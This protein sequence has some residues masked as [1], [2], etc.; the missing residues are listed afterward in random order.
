MSFIG[1]VH[2]HFQNTESSD[3]FV[4]CRDCGTSLEL[5]DEVCPSCDGRD[6]A[7]FDL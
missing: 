1:Y 3:V 7:R 2:Q 6:I 5:D 4:E